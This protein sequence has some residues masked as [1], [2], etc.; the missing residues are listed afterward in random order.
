[1]ILAVSNAMP[2][3]QDNF[4]RS[5]IYSTGKFPPSQ[6]TIPATTPTPD[7]RLSRMSF[8]LSLFHGLT[9]IS[10]QPL[11]SYALNPREAEQQYDTYA[12][13][14]DVLD[15]GSPSKTLG[16]D[17]ARNNLIKMARGDVLE[18]GAGTGLNLD[19]YDISRLSSLTLVD[20]SEG[21]LQQARGK[22]GEKELTD[23]LQ[24]SGVRVRLVK[25]D[26]TSE[27]VDQF[28]PE[29]FDT[30]VD[31]FSLCVMGDQGAKDCLRQI[32]QVV[33]KGKDGGQVLLLE[34]SRSS[35]LLL[36]AYQDITADVAASAGGKG[37]VYNQD[38]S[39]M[40]QES[41]ALS[42]LY[43]KPLVAGLFRSFIC[44]KI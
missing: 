17:Q 22:L 30:V 43:E 6:Q 11:S 16:I 31:S 20:I 27:L 33:K 12:P 10:M 37:C 40:I 2:I 23:K 34:N 38:V 7:Q 42:V 39:R 18:L 24:T 25:A 36:G 9:A 32:G 44:V 15:G 35:N 3:Q 28:G 41:G 21:M 4:S 1:M 19:K 5:D 29:A 14:Y 8:C 13:S 26:A